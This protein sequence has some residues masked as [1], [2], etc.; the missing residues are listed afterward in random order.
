MA[1]RG[2]IFICGAT[3][4]PGVTA[5]AP[6]SVGL[7]PPLPPTPAS[8][9]SSGSRPQPRVFPAR[10]RK[11]HRS[12]DAPATAS[13]F[14]DY[15]TQLSQFLSPLQPGFSRDLRVRLRGWDFHSKN[16]P[17]VVWSS[18]TQP[19]TAVV[20]P[21]AGY[22]AAN[23]AFLDGL[24]DILD[25]DTREGDRV[26]FDSK[27]DLKTGI[28][29]LRIRFPVLAQ[30]RG[31]A[32]AGAGV[33][34]AGA[35]GGSGDG[36]LVTAAAALASS[37]TANS[38]ATNSSAANYA[39][40]GTGAAGTAAASEPTT[41]TAAEAEEMK[42]ADDD[43]AHVDIPPEAYSI[44][45]EKDPDHCVKLLWRAT[46]DTSAELLLGKPFFR[47]ALV[48][49]RVCPATPQGCIQI[50]TLADKQTSILQGLAL[51]TLLMVLVFF[52][53]VSFSLITRQSRSRGD[54]GS[55]YIAGSTP[56]SDSLSSP[57]FVCRVESPTGEFEGYYTGHGTPE[58]RV[59]QS[60]MSSEDS[61][62]GPE[63]DLVNYE[64]LDA[65][66][67]SRANCA[68]I[69]T[70]SVAAGGGVPA[71][72]GG[73]NPRISTGQA[74]VAAGGAVTDAGGVI[75]GRR[76][77]STPTDSDEEISA[78]AMRRWTATNS[79]SD[80]WL[81]G[82]SNHSEGQQPDPVPGE[83]FFS[84]YVPPHVAHRA[85]AGG[86]TSSGPPQLAGRA[87]APGALADNGALL[88]DLG[89]RMC[90]RSPRSAHSQRDLLAASQS[91]G[92]TGPKSHTYAGGNSA[93]RKT[94]L[95][96]LGDVFFKADDDEIGGGRGA[97][98]REGEF[99]YLRLPGGAGGGRLSMS[100][101]SFSTSVRSSPRERATY[102]QAAITRS[103][104][105]R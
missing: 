64:A 31:S 32:G 6:S 12:R 104:L 63:F 42:L 82:C 100:R 15:T 68:R 38:S 54:Y 35:G 91:A 37:G 94:L 72:R 73:L 11:R 34:V 23:E 62:A 92:R 8:S 61:D 18:S 95:Q 57:S 70:N 40:T 59:L 49:Y 29:T 58:V 7:Y 97:G 2:L 26:C 96:W 20:D 5:G 47:I 28:P 80:T 51:A 88:N 1:F 84:N 89:A 93:S 33:A 4:S 71:G 44:P 36:T 41:V 56:S 46:N 101:G 55:G 90:G 76:S 13:S 39:T 19:V 48:G 81:G 30:P 77:T 25:Y 83:V 16:D 24:D 103:L 52:A 99:G 65:G 98:S 60:P 79:N 66:H 75:G 27:T 53:L 43:G 87:T 9:S 69:S 105:R 3:T 78:A 74:G 45:D 102:E 21:A 86:F 85:A 67:G 50:V 14:D 10:R 22:L 17:D